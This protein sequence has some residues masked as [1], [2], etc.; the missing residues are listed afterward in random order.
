M[1]SDDKEK[2]DFELH[3]I[4]NL[5]GIS[6][7]ELPFLMRLE[8]GELSALKNQIL[9]SMQNGQREIFVTIAKVS[10]YMPNF[11]NAKVSQDILGPQITANLSYFL[12]PKEAIAIAGYFPTKFFADVIEHLVPEKISEMIRLTPFDQMRKAVNELLERKSYFVIGSVMDYTPIESVDKIARGI[13]DPEHLIHIT[14]NCQDKK[15]V[16]ALFREFGEKRI[17]E[18]ITKGMTEEL[19]G[20]MKVI[21]EHADQLLVEFTQKAIAENDPSQMSLFE[22]LIQK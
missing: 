9:L 5:L 4:R 2:K 16:L 18:V 11:L 21:Y 14:Y 13:A 8:A 12:T 7:S 15:R 20:E 10:R 6:A 17:F 19:F 1:M 22:K 3:S